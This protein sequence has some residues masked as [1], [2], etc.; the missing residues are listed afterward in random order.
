[1]AFHEVQFPPTISINS[2][3]G[4]E[5]KTEVIQLGS[6]FEERNQRWADSRRKFNAGYGIKTLNDM[7]T[8]AA[9]YEERRGQLHGFRWKDW[10]DY[11]SC[12]PLTTPSNVDQNIGTGDGVT[13]TFQLRKQYG[14]SFAPYQRLI[15]KPVSGTVLIAVN[16][17]AK[18]ETTDYTIDYTTGIVT[19]GG[20][21]IPANGHAVTAGFQFDVPVRFDTDFLEM[22]LEPPSYGNI[23]D[24]PVI[25]IR[26]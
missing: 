16:G 21:D 2:R 12:P 17:V 13:A 15:K 24:I 1:M 8:I 25:E 5:R 23:A 10:A 4:A 20:G 19:F 22:Q 7:H 6:G 9:F 26:V 11:K 18:V 14:S 3:G